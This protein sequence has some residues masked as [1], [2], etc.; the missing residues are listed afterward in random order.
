VLVSNSFEI[1]WPPRTGRLQTFPEVDRAEW[2]DLDTA[3]TKI[4]SSQ[5]ELIDRLAQLGV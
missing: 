4:L 1:E 5:A 3:K 2:F